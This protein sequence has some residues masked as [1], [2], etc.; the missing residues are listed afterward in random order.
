MQIFWTGR[1]KPLQGILLPKPSTSRQPAASAAE[2]FGKSDPGGK[3]S[4][5]AASDIIYQEKE[6]MTQIDACVLENVTRTQ[7]SLG[8]SLCKHSFESKTRS[9]SLVTYFFERFY[10]TKARELEIDFNNPTFSDVENTTELAK[11][12]AITLDTRVKGK[13]NGS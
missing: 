7:I 3:D 4:I 6:N 9:A 2:A 11:F 12:C 10:E 1:N 13:I 5:V 8:A